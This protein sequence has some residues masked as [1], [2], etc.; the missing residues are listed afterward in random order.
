MAY[1]FIFI[2]NTKSLHKILEEINLIHPSIKFTMKHTF[3][4]ELDPCDCEKIS[5]VPFLDISLTLKDGKLST[6]LY[7][8]NQLIRTSIY[9][10]VAR[11]RF[12]VQ[13]TFLSLWQ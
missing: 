10:L 3:I 8:K 1:F 2:G 9:C 13:K 11:T 5:C 4:N 12:I 7:K 6:D